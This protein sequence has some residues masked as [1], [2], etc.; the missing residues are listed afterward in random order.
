MPLFPL[1]EG[2]LLV[3]HLR[4]DT[5]GGLGLWDT[6]VFGQDKVVLPPGMTLLGRRCLSVEG[7]PVHCQPIGKL[8]W[9]LRAGQIPGLCLVS[10]LP[11]HSLLLGQ[12]L[13][14]ARPLCLFIESGM[15][16]GATIST[17]QCLKWLL[18]G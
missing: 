4:G 17:C 6:P 16:D 3:G 9:V 12:R 8:A 5:A 11:E 2:V 13:G 7:S 14:R 15:G 10:D 1:I 18:H